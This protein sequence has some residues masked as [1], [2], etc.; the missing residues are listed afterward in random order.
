M[1]FRETVR[2]SAA[3][4]VT[5]FHEQWERDGTVPREVYKQGVLRFGVPEEYGGGGQ[6]ADWTRRWLARSRPAPFHAADRH[7]RP[8]PA[9]PHD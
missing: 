9:A 6:Q 1:A 8:L 2:E 5:P 4:Q 7:P 3:R